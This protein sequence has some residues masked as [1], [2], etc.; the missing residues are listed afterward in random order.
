M[1][2]WEGQY[3]LLHPQLK[4][5]CLFQYLAL[6]GTCLAERICT[7]RL[8]WMAP[9]IKFSNPPHGLFTG[10]ST[11]GMGKRKRE[12]N[13]LE[14]R[15][16][17]SFC[18]IRIEPFAF[19]LYRPSWFWSEQG[20]NDW[21]SYKDSYTTLFMAML[22]FHPCLLI[23][24]RRP[25]YV[26]GK[27]TFLCSVMTSLASVTCSWFSV[28]L[29]QSGLCAFSERAIP[30]V[31]SRLKD[32]LFCT[33]RSLLC[34]KSTSSWNAWSKS[35]QELLAIA[36][37]E[38]S[39]LTPGFSSAVKTKQ[40]HLWLI[41]NNQFF[42]FLGW[43]S[44]KNITKLKQGKKSRNGSWVSTYRQQLSQLSGEIHFRALIDNVTISLQRN[45]IVI[46][47]TV[48][49]RYLIGMTHKIKY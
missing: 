33:H 34:C 49:H 8:P 19:Y 26:L 6:L 18:P 40:P 44:P 14:A 5:D 16:V 25:S 38:E 32:H 30:G 36:V 47:L 7:D 27:V 46:F 12:K 43:G 9:W 42:C 29:S 1:T 17:P 3:P 23:S 31:I 41:S 48:F 37:P 10:F 22:Y 13:Y 21:P 20:K 4:L 35:P 45:C 24:Q 15:S 28:C 39:S 11:H 2:L